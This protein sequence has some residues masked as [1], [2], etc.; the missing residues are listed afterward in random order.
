[1]S[2]RTV[3]A[4]PRGWAS[5]TLTLGA[6]ETVTVRARCTAGY[7]WVAV[8]DNGY[9]YL[10]GRQSFTATSP[11]TLQFTAAVAGTYR[12]GVGRVGAVVAEIEVAP[13]VAAFW[14]APGPFGPASFWRR[15]VTEAAELEGS[16]AL[17]ADLVQQVAD[18]YGGT[19]ALNLT[20]YGV[21]CYE[22]GPDVPR[23]DVAFRD[24][25]RKGYV[26]H[27]I[28]Y[29]FAQVPWTA[30]MRGAKGTDGAMAIWCPATDQLW[31]WWRA[32]W[33]ES[34]PSAVWG[35]RIDNVS[36]SPGWFPDGMGCSAT[37]VATS[38]GCISV[39]DVAAGEIN[40]A[41]SLAIPR[42]ARH[43]VH[44]AQRT[45]GDGR[46][47]I[48]EGL[49]LRLDPDVDLEALRLTPIARMAARAAQRYGFVVT[50]RAGCVA[51]ATEVGVRIDGPSYSALARFPWHRLRAVTTP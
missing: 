18:Y 35:G 30:E 11:A 13:A 34:G 14:S 39:A 46:G 4:T 31:E 23:V 10:T 32:R 37:G 50:D 25:Q 47:T 16:A 17:V 27:Q 49:T 26:P 45:D 3:T 51:L 29:H 9:R 28:V 7:G 33:D 6:G 2:I 20:Q 42:A 41:L 44:P 24:E 22:V 19:A 48:P 15:D 38:R 8:L 43:F 12:V 21:A 5:W 36:T 1:M 40:H